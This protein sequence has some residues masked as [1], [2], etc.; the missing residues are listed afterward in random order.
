MYGAVGDSDIHDV[1]NMGTGLQCYAVKGRVHRGQMALFTKE[2]M[3]QRGDMAGLKHAKSNLIYL[4][5]STRY[6]NNPL[7]ALI[8]PLP[9][10]L[11]SLSPSCVASLVTA[12]ISSPRYLSTFPFH[13]PSFASGWLL[14]DF[15][16]R[17]PTFPTFLYHLRRATTDCVLSPTGSQGNL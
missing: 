13:R 8:P 14:L 12:A 7:Y 15:A 17:T 9:L 16:T 3:I 10:F 5:Y 6:I 2:A 1:Y 11:T 4:L